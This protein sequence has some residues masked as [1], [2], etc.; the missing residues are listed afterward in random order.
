MKKMIAAVLALSVPFSAAYAETVIKTN[1]ESSSIVI[2]GE[3]PAGAKV[4]EVSVNIFKDGKTP[5]GI[6]AENVGEMIEYSIQTAANGGGEFNINAPIKSGSGKYTVYVDFE[7]N[8]DKQG[9]IV[10]FVTAF[11]N[12]EAVRD[13]FDAT[14]LEESQRIMRV[15][16]DLLSLTNEYYDGSSTD[17]PAAMFYGLKNETPA[18][19][20]DH[21]TAQ[22][23][24]DLACTLAAIS[25]GKITDVSAHFDALELTG[26]KAAK[27]YTAGK[28]NRRTAAGEILKE[29]DLDGIEKMK[30][31]FEE[32]VVL[33]T[34]QCPDGIADVT[35]VIKGF[36]SEIGISSPSD[37]SKVYYALMGKKCKSYSELLAAYKEALGSKK[38]TSGGG[39]SSGGG[40]GISL[41]GDKTGITTAIVGD[42]SGERPENVTNAV[43]AFSDISV[44]P[45]AVEAISDLADK[46]IIS[47]MGDGMFKPNDY[48]T[49]EQFV[50]MIVNA[51]ELKSGGGNAKFID[52]NE[53]DWFYSAVM[54]AYE[55]EI[56]SGRGDSF[57]AGEYL[58]RED[59]AVII[60]NTVRKTGIRAEE[61]ARA[62]FADSEE[63]SDYAKESV[64]YLK[65][66]G[67]L[68]GNENNE[69]N[70]K[71]TTT[72]A[73]AAVV[74]NSVLNSIR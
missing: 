3:I 74:I 41:R 9:R 46:G 71:N 32:A 57:G 66:I 65:N 68:N 38:G 12:G 54:T 40:G 10:S 33:A 20:K 48:V 6:T 26:T 70:P 29:R 43:N 28:T 13:L 59:M 18:E 56:V 14:S 45:W 19:N 69:F 73:E 67:I 44:V 36:A 52:V 11:D 22:K 50:K 51:F 61:T 1:V 4:N 16:W 53:D 72:R 34:V 21:A 63:I 25:D 23:Y 49:R 55:N 60:R 39:S 64:E 7:G 2:S 37:S 30:K 47:G 8:T 15:K 17:M 31:A 5:A 35:N 24:F 58:T 27:Y 62:P 42:F